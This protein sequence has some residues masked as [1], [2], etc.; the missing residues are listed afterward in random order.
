MRTPARASMLVRARASVKPVTRAA[1]ARTP[2][3]ARAAAP[4][5]STSARPT[6]PARARAAARPATR[7][8][9]ARTPAKARAA[10]RSCKGE[11]VHSLEVKTAAANRFCGLPA[12][13]LSE[14]ISYERESMNIGD[15]GWASGFAP[16]TFPTFWRLAEVDSSRLSRRT[17]WIRTD[18]PCGCWIRWPTVSRHHVRRLHV[19]RQHRPARH[20]ISAHQSAR[21]SH[22]GTIVSDHLC[23]TLRAWA[24]RA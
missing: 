9:R 19:H 3:K 23:F 14:G 6:I 2:A 24:Q 18:G 21:R 1:R 20:G 22:Q 7:A 5:R 10:A 15:W 8:A 12:S 11:V 16:R 17:S 4:L 13:R